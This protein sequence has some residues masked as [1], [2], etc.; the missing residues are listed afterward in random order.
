MSQPLLE[1]EALETHFFT[2]AGVVRAA[3]GVSFA[4]E[5]GEIVGLV[6]ESGSGKTVTGFSLLG[7]VDEPGRIVGGAVR[8]DG[9]DLLRLPARRLR[10]VRGRRIAMVFQDPLS[11]LNPVF[12]VGVQLVDALK[13]TRPEVPASAR[14]ARAVEM[15]ARVGVADPD[16]RFAAYPHELSGGMRQRATIAMALLCQPDLLIADEPTTAL[17]ATIG[18]QILRLFAELKAELSS[19]ILFISHS[20]GLVAELCDEVAVM[21][22]GEVVEHAPAEALFASPRHPYTRALLA[23][24]TDAT[25]E[26]RTP[27]IPGEPP[28]LL[29]PPP[30]CAFAPRCPQ[31]AEA[32]ARAPALRELGGGRR[33]A[34]HFA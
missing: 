26:G 13:A 11:A 32:C 18:A 1:V 4:L 5:R 17:D 10:S 23:C 28:D 3:D 34:C 19:T 16:V 14:R 29:D 7:L 30:G 27:T 21:Y 15:L 12:T 9:V 22:G 20:L 6:G 2:R 25:A 24:E 33:A 8:L 31:A